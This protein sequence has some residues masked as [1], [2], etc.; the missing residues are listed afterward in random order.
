MVNG[1]A[2]Y[3]RVPWPL[4]QSGVRTMIAAASFGLMAFGF[5]LLVVGVAHMIKPARDV[6]AN[7]KEEISGGMIGE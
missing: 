2:G 1:L 4:H 6:L 5:V 7:W 3:W